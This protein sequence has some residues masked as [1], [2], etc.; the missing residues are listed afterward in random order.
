MAFPDDPSCR[1]PPQMPDLPFRRMPEFG[2]GLGQGNHGKGFPPPNFNAAAAMQQQGQGV[3][4]VAVPVAPP[5]GFWPP[6]PTPGWDISIKPS[7]CTRRYLRQQARFRRW[8]PEGLPTF[9]TTPTGL[10]PAETVIRH[11]SFGHPR[12][13]P[14]PPPGPIPGRWTG[15]PGP[16]PFPQPAPP[17]TSFPNPNCPGTSHATRA[18]KRRRNSCPTTF[19]DSRKEKSRRSSSAT[20]CVPPAPSEPTTLPTTSTDLNTNSS[21]CYACKHPLKSNGTYTWVNAVPQRSAR[22]SET[23][24]SLYDDQ[25]AVLTDFYRPV[26]REL[27]LELL[28]NWLFI[29]EVR[30][31]SVTD[32]EREA[33]LTAVRISILP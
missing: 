31:F 6:P 12:P 26:G 27:W 4:P 25:Q 16:P 10:T 22:E 20:A 8:G 17:E 19:P 18:N 29:D 32:E 28:I 11:A 9:P 7:K 30:D 23:P 1:Q 3:S 33:E 21:T 5:P 13:P 14:G 15:I 24:L 2:P